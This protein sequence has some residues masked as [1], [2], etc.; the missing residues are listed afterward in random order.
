[1]RIYR[2]FCVAV[3][4]GAIM[5]A[6]SFAQFENGPPARIQSINRF[7]DNPPQAVDRMKALIM[8]PLGE[9]ETNRETGKDATGKPEYGHGTAFLVS[10]CYIITNFHIIY[11]IP[12]PHKP[13][14]DY[15]MLFNI[16]PVADP[17]A[18]PWAI[19]TI[20]ARVVFAGNY[21]ENGPGDWAVLKLD[22]CVGGPPYNL[23][24]FETLSL[25]NEKLL[26]APVTVAGFAGDHKYGTLSIGSGKVTG[27]AENGLLMFS[28][29]MAHGQSGGPIFAGVKGRAP[30][31]VGLNV[32]MRVYK[33]D[34]SIQ[35]DTYSDYRANEFI[36]IGTIVDDPKIKAALDAD[37]EGVVNAHP[38]PVMPKFAS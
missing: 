4:L 14:L 21:Q 16:G 30:M 19:R 33:G 31:V 24:W 26:G 27:V 6:A 35:F 8:L 11:G 1:M 9:L 13:G 12:K 2:M 25:P 20:P 37:R 32:R 3:G 34:K 29:S 36:S 23:G 15:S 38:N 7:A 10:P 22:K 18:V 28:A 17:N 5:S